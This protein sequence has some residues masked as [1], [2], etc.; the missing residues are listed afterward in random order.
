MIRVLRPPNFVLVLLLGASAGCVG[1]APVTNDALV[2]VPTLTDRALTNCTFDRIATVE[3]ERTGVV[4]NP[5]R[6]MQRTL[7]LKAR[8]L[9]ADAIMEV[10]VASIVPPAVPGASTNGRRATGVRASA[11]A[12]RFTSPRCPWNRKARD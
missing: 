8:S 6:E 11:V 9:G 4:V 12:I 10:K 5:Q 7:G 3:E 1:K 2:P